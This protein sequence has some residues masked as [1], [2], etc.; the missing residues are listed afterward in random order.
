MIPAGW[1]QV[2]KGSLSPTES[3]VATRLF[4]A[5][6][7]AMG[8]CEPCAVALLPSISERK[9]ISVTKIRYYVFFLLFFKIVSK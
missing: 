8:P 2:R 6:K 4:F 7:T 9:S 3:L 1:E 5:G